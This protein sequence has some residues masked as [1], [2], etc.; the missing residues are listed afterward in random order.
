MAEDERDR[1]LDELRV[2]AEHLPFDVWVRDRYDRCV[3]GNATAQ[4]HWP[5]FVGKTVAESGVPAEVQAIWRANNA[6]ALAGELVVG[7]VV[8]LHDGQETVVRNYIAPVRAPSGDIVGTV[9]VN[10]DI[11]AQRSAERARDE[12]RAMLAAVFDAADLAMGVREIVADDD[13]V[14]LDDNAASAAVFGAP[15]T[16]VGRRDSE[17]GVPRRNRVAAVRVARAAIRRRQPLAF[18]VTY[19]VPGRGPRAFEGKVAPLDP[20]FTGGAERF[21]FLAQDVTEIRAMEAELLRAERLASLGTLAASVAHEIRNPATALTFLL[22]EVRELVAASPSLDAA[23]RAELRERL[24]DA[25]TGVAQIT[26]LSADLGRLARPADDVTDAV[27]L[28]EVVQCS[29]GLARAR[30]QAAARLDLALGDP[31]PLRASAVRLGQVVLNLLFNAAQALERAGRRGTVRVRT[32]RAGDEVR[33]EVEDDGP[34]LPADVRARLFEPFVASDRGS[35]LG[36]YVCR[37]IVDA[38][39]GTIEARENPA[40]SGTTV[41]VRLPLPRG[42]AYTSLP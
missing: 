1:V 24:D 36:L 29:V 28:D 21:L 38:H 41:V 5:G 40:G 16:L 3:Y 26:R 7:D 8:Y 14:H 23:E 17:L 39:G 37:Q 19:D 18:E 32:L 15:P 13:M 34:G 12:R 27:S 31:P 33:L 35:G 22:D 4:R 20:A 25:A 9:G 2:L 30:V 11:T 6:R 42:P 10:V